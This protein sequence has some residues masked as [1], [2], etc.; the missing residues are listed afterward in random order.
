VTEIRKKQSPSV[1]LYDLA[2][3]P[4]QRLLP[5]RIVSVQNRYTVTE[6]VAKDYRV[7]DEMFSLEGEHSDAL[8]R[9]AI[10]EFRKESV[11]KLDYRGEDKIQ[12]TDSQKELRIAFNDKEV[13]QVRAGRR[14]ICVLTR[15]EWK[16]ASGGHFHLDDCSWME[17]PATEGL[18]HLAWPTCRR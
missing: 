18:A 14:I 2:L 11:G 5:G 3:W 4:S 15:V 8:D 1:G 9:K 12:G 16:N 10:A 17:P 7:F 6:G 13:A